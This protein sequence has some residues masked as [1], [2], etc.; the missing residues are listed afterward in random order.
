MIATNT[1]TS[2][3]NMGE[4]LNL[5]IFSNPIETVAISFDHQTGGHAG[6]FLKVVCFIPSS[7]RKIVLNSNQII[8]QRTKIDEGRFKG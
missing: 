3:S 1:Q 7:F 2:T 4:K 6:N 8:A 5:M